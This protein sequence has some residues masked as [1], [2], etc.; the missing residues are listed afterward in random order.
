MLL[1]PT[2]NHFIY[3]DLRVYTTDTMHAPITFQV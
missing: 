2:P 3:E 1:I